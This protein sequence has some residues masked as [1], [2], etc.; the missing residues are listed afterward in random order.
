[1]E[2]LLYD[3][4]FSNI[5]SYLSG[6]ISTMIIA[7]ASRRTIYCLP[8]CNFIRFLSVF[9]GPNSVSSDISVYNSRKFP[10]VSTVIN[11][12]MPVENLMILRKWQEKM[13][14]QMGEQKFNEYISRKSHIANS[15]V[16]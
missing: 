16:F 3:A 12:T 6:P 1:M 15:F 4:D 9:D 7:I 5:S 14:K 8:V 10:T 11:K 2:I 13:R